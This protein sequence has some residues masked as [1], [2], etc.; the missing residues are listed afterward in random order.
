MLIIIERD[1]FDALISADNFG[2]RYLGQWAFSG[3]TNF[4]S[5]LGLNE[6][7]SVQAVYAPGSGYELLYGGVGYEQPIGSAG[8]RIGAMVSITDTEPGH[9]LEEF[10]V[11]G[12]GNLYSLYATH[13]FIRSRNENLKGTLTFDWRDVESRNIVEPTREDNIRAVRAGLQ[14]DFLD[15]LIGVAVNSVNL[16]ISKGLNIFGASEEGDA[17]MSRSQ[18]DPQFTKAELGVQR[19]Q[20]LSGSVNLQLT[21]KAQ[22]ASN[23]L[24]SSEEMGVGGVYSGRGYDPS[25]IV[26]DHG[27]SGQAELQWN[28]PITLD[29]PAVER[30]QLYTFLDA[31]RVWN[32]D[33]T[34]AADERASLVSTGVGARVNLAHDVQA[35]I[36]VAFPLTRRVESEDDRDPRLYLNF[37]KKF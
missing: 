21:G 10:D 8:T 28:N 34:T 5:L 3:V 26:G 1:P 6:L 16:K 7:I 9:G 17:N 32:E 25:E 19:L 37:S 30:L 31:G 24:P 22:I 29:M 2:S 18:A 13:P 15:T 23:A 12:R 27:I 4:N 14:Y 20:R 35:G 11:R 36:G 33:A